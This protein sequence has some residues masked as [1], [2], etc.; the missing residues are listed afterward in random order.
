MKTWPEMLVEVA[1]PDATSHMLEDGTKGR[2]RYL[3]EMASM[4]STSSGESDRNSLTCGQAVTL[5]TVVADGCSN[6]GL[7]ALR[8]GCRNRLLVLLR[9]AKPLP[10]FVLIVPYAVLAGLSTGLGQV[11]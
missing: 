5:R 9:R 2:S 4:L 6:G 8:H 7:E 10:E 3:Q 11:R 1:R